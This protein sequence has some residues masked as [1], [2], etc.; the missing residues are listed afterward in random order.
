[1]CYFTQ[2]QIYLNC[3]NMWLKFCES[4]DGSID[5]GDELER[6]RAYV[7]FCEGNFGDCYCGDCVERGLLG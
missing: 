6:R 3:N 5:W 7:I 4:C 2:I 1:M